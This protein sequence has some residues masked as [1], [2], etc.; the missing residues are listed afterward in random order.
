VLKTGCAIERRQL[1]SKDALL[2][3]LGLFVPIAVKMLALRTR[4]RL[5]PDTPVGQ[6]LSATELEALRLIA[7]A[8]L[9]PTIT[10][11]QA[12]L[13]IAAVGG[14][15]RNNGPPGWLTIARGFETLQIAA[16]VCEARAR[17]D[18]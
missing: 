10:A 16:H 2:N 7:R 8:P 14:H 12:L 9:P 5:N 4:A 18:Q 13:A 15:L 17:S 3:C 11:Q 1:E 6:L